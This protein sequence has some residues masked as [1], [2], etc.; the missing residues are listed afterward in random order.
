MKKLQQE[1]IRKCDQVLNI[2]AVAEN[3]TESGDNV[4]DEI[5]AAN[6]LNKGLILEIKSLLDVA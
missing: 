6:L 4:L 3:L 5:R 1:A 2:L